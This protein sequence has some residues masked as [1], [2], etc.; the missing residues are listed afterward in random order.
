MIEKL[1]NNGHFW[2][3]KIFFTFQGCPLFRGT[4]F[5]VVRSSGIFRTFFHEGGASPKFLNILSRKRI[6]KR[7]KSR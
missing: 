3:T 2:P 4:K 1:P 6:D 5:G 7:K